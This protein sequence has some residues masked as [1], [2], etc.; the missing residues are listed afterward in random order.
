MP[1]QRLDGVLRGLVTSCCQSHTVVHSV[2]NVKR[3]KIQDVWNG[4]ILR[5]IRRRMLLG[6]KEKVCRPDCPSLLQ[7]T[8]HF[9]K[10]KTDTE[11]DRK[12]K[13][14]LVNGRTA[15]TV[16]PNYFALSNW[17]PCN[18]RCIMCDSWSENPMALGQ[19]LAAKAL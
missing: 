19:P 8:I 2:G 13:D 1:W 3:R 5:R 18:L 4:P 14:D 6:K 12:L 17:G 9:D 11:Y 15:L 16:S 7:P 10:M